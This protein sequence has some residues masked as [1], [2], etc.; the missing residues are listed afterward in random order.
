[1]D[2]HSQQRLRNRGGSYVESHEVLPAY[3]G[4]HLLRLRGPIGSVKQV[5][6]TDPT[7]S[8]LATVDAP[9]GQQQLRG[10][11]PAPTEATASLLALLREVLTLPCAGNVYFA[12]ALYWYK[13][14]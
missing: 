8:V 3:P 5:S 9:V 4:G 6:L 7:Y 11:G 14:H 12:I 2:N 1:M 10:A 13:T